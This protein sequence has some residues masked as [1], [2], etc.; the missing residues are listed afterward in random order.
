MSKKKEEIVIKFPKEQIVKAKVFA[1][2]KDAISAILK[3]GKEYTIEEAVL[4]LQNF[5]EGGK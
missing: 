3:D 2:H 4:E 5:M 1:N